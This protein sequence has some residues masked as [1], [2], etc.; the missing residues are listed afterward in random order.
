MEGV[1]DLP[2]R[3]WFTQTSTPDFATTPFLRITRDYPYKRVPATFCPEM[4]VLKNLTPGTVAPQLMA[5]SVSDLCRIGEHFLKETAFIDINCGCPAPTVVGNGAGSAL[6]IRAEIFRNYVSEVCT[7]L[8]PQQVSIKMR[9]GF[10]DC[11]EFDELLDVL[12]GCTPRRLTVHGRTRADR[13]LGSAKWNLIERAAQALQA[14][15]PRSNNEAFL[16]KAFSHLA[17]APKLECEVVGSGDV[18]SSESFLH[19]LV[20]APHVQ[21]VIVGRGALRNPWIFSELRLGRK[22]DLSSLTLKLSLACFVLLQELCERK[23]KDVFDL[24]NK[25]VFLQAAGTQVEAWQEL[26]QKLWASWTGHSVDQKAAPFDQ[27]EVGRGAF[28]KLK[29]MWNSLRS[30]LPAAFFGPEPLRAANLSQFFDALDRCCAAH[31]VH[32]GFNSSKDLLTLSYEP[33]HDW[34]YSG[35]GKGEKRESAG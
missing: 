32:N 15:G 5:S 1:T 16:Q 34:V 25:G 7:N 29:M 22:V 14:L 13:Y 20:V 23:P 17:L 33:T 8:G 31:S 26:Y 21:S 9:T 18:T 6:L 2:T 24:A 30:A 10:L 4:S 35:G 12:V 3:L 11:S 19:R 28:C 27:L